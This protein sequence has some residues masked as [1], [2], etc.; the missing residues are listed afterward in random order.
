VQSNQTNL[1]GLSF[2][3]TPDTAEL[4]V[5][6]KLVGTVGQFTPTTQPL[7]LEAGHHQIEIRATGYHTTNFDVDVIAGQVTPYKGELE[8]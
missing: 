5:D 2:E 3:I 6:G 1:G 7:G 4:W 8:R